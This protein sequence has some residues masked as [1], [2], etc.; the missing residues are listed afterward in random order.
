[1]RVSPAPRA[2][3]ALTNVN[4]TFNRQLTPVNN[5][6]ASV[7]DKTVDY[8]LG[9][10]PSARRSLSHVTTDPGLSLFYINI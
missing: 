6:L 8:E 10:F 3:G 1:M 9:R 7:V 5:S 4:H 2:A